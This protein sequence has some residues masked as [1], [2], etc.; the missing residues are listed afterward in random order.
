MFNNKCNCGL[1][2]R[3]STFGPDGVIGESCNKYAQC[4]TYDVL[5]AD[6]DSYYTEMKR[7]KAALDKIVAVNGMD[8]EYK[9]WAK[10]ALDAK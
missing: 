5:L 2:V 8:Y 4:P 10:G 1:P 9:A 6:R 3:Y 7:Y